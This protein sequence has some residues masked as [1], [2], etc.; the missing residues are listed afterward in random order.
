M[1]IDCT[2]IQSRIASLVDQTTDTPT[3]GG[4][5]WLL[6]LKY[7]NRAIEEFG[8]AFDWEGLRK[9]HW[10]S[11]TSV[12]GASVSLPANFRKMSAYPVYYSGGVSEGEEWP[13]IAADKKGLY[14][15][16][17]K[18][19]YVLGNRADGHTMVWN[20][21]TL[22]SG[23]S[24]VISYYSFPTSLASPADTV[25]I[26]DPEYLVNRVTAYIFESRNDARFQET[27]AKARESLLNM[28]ENEQVTKYTPY[29]GGTAGNVQTDN[30]LFHSF[31]IGRD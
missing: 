11:T 20:P 5:E 2:E 4:S 8:Q 1:A 12:S 26:A 29:A 30:R 13:E 31:R 17:D 24:L 6:R 9:D 15:S 18:Y 16:T 28:I 19:Y 22:A 10:I 27:E 21:G 14:T 23:A 7:I 3:V 25:N